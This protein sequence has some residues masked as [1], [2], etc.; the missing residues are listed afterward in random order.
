MDH[1][2]MVLGLE[3]SR[4]SRSCK[5]WHHLL[6]VCG[7]FGALL[8]DQG[9]VY[10]P[11][12]PNDRLVL[13]LKPRRHMMRSTS[14]PVIGSGVSAD[15]MPEGSAVPSVVTGRLS[16]RTVFWTAAPPCGSGRARSWFFSQRCAMKSSR[17][18][19]RT[20]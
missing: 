19:Q 9:G 13:G 1:V 11:S 8:A 4:L 10:D 15:P 5:D 3:M 20:A 7:I 14:G 6:E 12:D 2:G 17:V 18:V 16:L